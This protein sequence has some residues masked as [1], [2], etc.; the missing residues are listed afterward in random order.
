VF[1]NDYG[2]KDE[3][4]RAGPVRSQLEWLAKDQIAAL[5]Y[6]T[7]KIRSLRWLL[8]PPSWCHRY[9]NGRLVRK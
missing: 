6:G 7:A 4:H 3:K 9:S 1:R 2:F 8:K 5:S